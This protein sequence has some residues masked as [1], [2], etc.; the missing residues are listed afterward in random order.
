MPKHD[1]EVALPAHHV[2]NADLRIVVNS[3]GR[4]L[5]E[6]LISKG[7]LDWRSSNHH[8]R[9][10]MPWETFASVMERWRNG[11]LR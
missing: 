7:T 3:D 1:I 11:E 8:H 5:G 4:K 10:S 9:V 6:L 2:V